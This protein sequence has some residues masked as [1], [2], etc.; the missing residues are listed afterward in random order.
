MKFIE[1]LE[2]C[3]GIKA[4]KNLMPIQ[5]EMYLLLVQT[6]MILLKISVLG[7]QHQLKRALKNLWSGIKNTINNIQR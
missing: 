6:L 2:D 5:P 3:L 7:H 4:K 1:I